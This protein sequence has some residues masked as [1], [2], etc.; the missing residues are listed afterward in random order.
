MMQD[1]E[2]NVFFQSIIGHNIGIAPDGRIITDYVQDKYGNRIE[3]RKIINR[4]GQTLEIK[5]HTNNHD[6]NIFL[7]NDGTVSY[8]SEI[9]DYNYF[10]G[11]D[12]DCDTFKLKRITYDQCYKMQFGHL[13]SDWEDC[14]DDYYNDYYQEEVRVNSG[15][16]YPELT[17]FIDD[18]K[19]I[20]Y[21]GRFD[22]YIT[23]V[24]CF[25]DNEI[26]ADV[27]IFKFTRYMGYVSDELPKFKIVKG[28]VYSFQNYLI[29]GALLELI[30]SPN[31]TLNCIYNN[32]TIVYEIKN[33]SKLIKAAMH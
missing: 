6:E 23:R 16:E 32:K 25:G 27:D 18:P 33:K 21:F 24:Y 5:K 12:L 1:S 26:C 3:G 11:H 30:D 29:S 4:F 9:A 28:R 8:N 20:S 13:I 10:N 19:P 7:L 17:A 22:L 31:Y 2:G 15:L 14:D